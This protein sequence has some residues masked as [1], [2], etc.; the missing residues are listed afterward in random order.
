MILD[1]VR[2]RRLVPGQHLPSQ[3]LADMFKVSRAPINAAL[4]ELHDVGVVRFEPNRGFFLADDAEAL[5]GQLPTSADAADAEDAVYLRIAEDRLAGRLGD[6][7]SEAE[8]M[9]LYAYPRN[10]LSKILYRIA[11]EGWAERLPGSGWEFKPM[12]TSR[13]SYEQA[14]QF[15]ASI[16]AE[17]LRQSTYEIDPALF[18]HARAEQNFILAEG[19]KT[20]SRADIFRANSSFHEMLVGC[21]G[22][23][24]FLDAVKR[25]NRLR[26]LIEYRVTLDRSRLPDQSREHLMLL[27]LLEAGQRE[28]AAVFMHRHI[29]G[30][31]AIKSPSVGK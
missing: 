21:A 20:M 14:Y 27:D 7:V 1:E 11:E 9:R 29:L 23:D 17:A 13:A 15:R 18:A 8:L 2:E 24:F 26:R 6:R 19:H 10:R 30:A 3:L 22:N 16:E 31:S 4:K 28:A 5:A 25:V 12:L